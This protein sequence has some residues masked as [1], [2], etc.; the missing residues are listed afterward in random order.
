[1]PELKLLRK[2]LFLIALMVVGCLVRAQTMQVTP[3]QPA[4]PR[5][6]FHVK[7]IPLTE[8]QIQGAIAAAPGVK[9]TT[10]IAKEGINELR[11]ATVAKLDAVAKEHG[12]ASYEEF[13]LVW[14][15]LSLVESGF[16]R[17]SRKY[18]GRTALTKLQ[19]AKIKADMTMSAEDKRDAIDALDFESPAPRY[20]ANVDLFIKYY[21]QMRGVDVELSPGFAH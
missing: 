21:D 11:P 15:N 7:Q 13:L 17:M 16:D 6:V 19:I 10:E 1:L 8:R 5:R 3:V 12:L 18:I 2:F 14:N 9:E 4:H 20:K